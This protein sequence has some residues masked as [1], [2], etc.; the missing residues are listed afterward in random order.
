[1]I[2]ACVLHGGGDVLP[3]ADHYKVNG[4]CAA[5]LLLAPQPN[6][7]EPVPGEDGVACRRTR[8]SVRV[9]QRGEVCFMY[10]RCLRCFFCLT[11]N[12]Q[13]YFSH[14]FL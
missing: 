13:C 3:P 9:T 1:M 2:A 8:F 4:S 14:H 7:W 12:V 10:L 11:V 5:P 6:K